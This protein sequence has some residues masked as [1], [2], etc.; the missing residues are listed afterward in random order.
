M[1]SIVRCAFAFVL[2][3]SSP[4]IS[5]EGAMPATEVTPDDWVQAL[6]GE[7]IRTL[8][9]GIGNDFLFELQ[10]RDVGNL[11]S[12][13]LPPPNR[14]LED[15]DLVVVVKDDWAT[16]VTFWRGVGVQPLVDGVSPYV[17]LG[18]G[19]PNLVMTQLTSPQGQSIRVYTFVRS[20]LGEVQQ[21]RCMARLVIN[22]TYLGPDYSDF[23][24]FTC[25]QALR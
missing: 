12:Y 9:D 18:D 10:D 4:A 21:E 14:T 24:A 1:N 16:A 11:F 17:G 5:Q 25:S 23:N 19:A 15:S 3:A 20:I 22:E 7:R 13:G 6:N 2:M 8:Y